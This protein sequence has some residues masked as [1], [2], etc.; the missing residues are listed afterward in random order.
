MNYRPW[1]E[2]QVLRQMTGLPEDAF[3]ALTQTLARICEDPYDRLFSAALLDEN[4]ARRMAEL[5]DDAGFIEFTVNEA[6]G[7]VHVY[8]LLWL[9]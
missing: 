5:G 1:L 7:L 3:D 9:G 8:A 6:E 4:P 2:E